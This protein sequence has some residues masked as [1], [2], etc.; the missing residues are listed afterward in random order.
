LRQA[1]A[2]QK[3]AEARVGARRFEPGLNRQSTN[4]VIA[5]VASFAQPP[6]CLVIVTESGM[7]QSNI[8]CG[9]E[10]ELLELL[11]NLSGLGLLTGHSV[12]V[13][14]GSQEGRVACAE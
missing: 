6:E 3:F 9:Y 10:R 2:A 13:A 5:F 11:K 4:P 8:E 12:S 14:Q 1:D 7:E